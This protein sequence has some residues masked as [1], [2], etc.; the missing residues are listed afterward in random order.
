M[1]NLSGLL[2]SLPTQTDANIAGARRFAHAQNAQCFEHRLQSR[3]KS[4]VASGT[5]ITMKP[6]EATEKTTLFNAAANRG[7]YPVIVGLVCRVT[8]SIVLPDVSATATIDCVANIYERTALHT[9]NVSPGKAGKDF[10]MGKTQS[11]GRLQK[12]FDT[13]GGFSQLMKSMRTATTENTVSNARAARSTTGAMIMSS[14]SAG[15]M[16]ARTLIDDLDYRTSWTTSAVLADRT[17]PQSGTQYQDCMFFP[18]TLDGTH[19][20]V[21]AGMLYQ[22]FFAP[23]P[24]WQFDVTLNDN[25]DLYPTVASGGAAAVFGTY[26]VEWSVIYRVSPKKLGTICQGS[27][28]RLN[29]N[30]NNVV[31]GN[32]SALSAAQVRDHVF[33]GFLP[34]AWDASTDGGSF[35]FLHADANGAA[36]AYAPKMRIISPV[37]NPS[38]NF[39]TDGTYMRVGDGVTDVLPANPDDL[40]SRGDTIL[41]EWNGRYQKAAVHDPTDV[42]PEGRELPTFAEVGLRTSTTTLCIDSALDLSVGA[43]GVRY[44]ATYGAGANVAYNAV[45]TANDAAQIALGGLPLLPIA[46]SDMQSKG[47]CGLATRTGDDGRP[48]TV[49]T[50]GSFAYPALSPTNASIWNVSAITASGPYVEMKS[51]GCDPCGGGSIVEPVLNKDTSNRKAIGKLLTATFAIPQVMTV[52]PTVL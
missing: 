21:D 15:L 36:A 19:G 9:I 38:V 44:G 40:L 8:Q 52:K 18:L 32:Q 4:G 42:Y 2:S 16:N 27:V 48:I 34:K 43:A 3:T 47:F 50:N 20:V 24:L 11:I 10:L 35:Y 7:G 30:L 49:N 25:V 39:N 5:T 12:I 51:D 17:S 6:T 26:T 1:N 13:V 23:A 22:D 37:V 28:W 29:D 14:D 45:P 31:A 41:T 46:W 33:V